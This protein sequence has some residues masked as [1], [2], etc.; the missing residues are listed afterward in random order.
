[1][2]SSVLEKAEYAAAREQDSQYQHQANAKL[3]EGRA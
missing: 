1:M 2:R 3:P